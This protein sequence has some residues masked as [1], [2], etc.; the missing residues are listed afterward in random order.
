MKR[1]LKSYSLFFKFIEA[2][3]PRNFLGIDR[4]D[5][6]V[7]EIE[8]IMEINNQ[9]FFAGDMIQ[10]QINYTSNRSI[11]MIG[12][13]PGEISP[14]HFFEA[15]HPDDMQRHSLARTKLFSLANDLF[16]AKKG[17][18]L[19]SANIKVRNPEGG[20]SNLLI[21][22][23]LFYSALPVKTVYLIQ[24]H[25]DIESFKKSKNDY[26]YYAGNDLSNFR[27]PDQELLNIGNPLSDREFEIVKLIAAG[28]SSE[29]IADRI[30]LS[31]H[32]IN[33]HR[34]NILKKT[35][36]FTIS[37]LIFDFMNQGLL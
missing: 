14:Y 19:L 22:C 16:I 20:Y 27:Y 28:L 31:V 2:Y 6:L 1:D 29:Q 26:H 37:E 21:Q 30:F 7:S 11:N 10:I 8:A 4:N 17:D 13:E 12:V 3:A 36:F 32:T 24:I 35:G 5:P 18:A 25:T 23:Y 9:F 34:G 15:T 33:T